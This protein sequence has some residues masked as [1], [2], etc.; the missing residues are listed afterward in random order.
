MNSMKTLSD[1]LD[2]KVTCYKPNLQEKHN[3]EKGGTWAP[4]AN[5]RIS[6]SSKETGINLFPDFNAGMGIWTKDG[7][8]DERVIVNASNA[9]LSNGQRYNRSEPS[10]E[11]QALIYVKAMEA[12][13]KDGFTQ[14]SSS[15]Y[16]AKYT[17]ME[18]SAVIDMT[19][20]CIKKAREYQKADGSSGAPVKSGKAAI[21]ASIAEDASDE[22]LPV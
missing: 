6:I 19:R 22:G 17:G 2:I 12:F 11:L 5:L 14:A 4:I 21:G 18:E 9:Q 8:A 15:Q 16:V 1:V 20:A 10:P 13:E 7:S 3:E